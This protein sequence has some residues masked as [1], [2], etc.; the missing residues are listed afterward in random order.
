[1]LQVSPNGH[2]YPNAETKSWLSDRDE[3]WK[4]TDNYPELEA[5]ADGKLPGRGWAVGV[6][7]VPGMIFKGSDFSRG[8]PILRTLTGRA[9][10]GRV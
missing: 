1:M 4:P 10:V 9:G 2:C 7:L 3:R 6:A 5:R 8:P